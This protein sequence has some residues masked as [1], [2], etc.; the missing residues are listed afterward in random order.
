[1]QIDTQ[2]Y[3]DL[4]ED[5]NG[6]VFWDIEAAGLKADYGSII[7]CSFKPYGRKPYTY[8]VKTYGDDELLVDSIKE[9]LEYYKC[10][11]T[12]YG[13]GFDVPMVNTRL[14]KWGGINLQPKH[15][16]DLYFTLK[17]KLNLS[18]KSMASLAGFL[19]TKQQKMR[20]NQDV[21]SEMPFNMNKHMPTMI[22][23]CESD[24]SVLEHVYNKTRHLIK[25][26]K[27]G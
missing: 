27:K 22:K 17:S 21:W 20:V 12:Y 5:T 25:E 13:K 8:H 4:M 9:E 10:W 2:E 15:H 6:L 18:S 16:I 23:R 11:V 7:C 14:L 3:L 1:M 26:I 24:C 19:N